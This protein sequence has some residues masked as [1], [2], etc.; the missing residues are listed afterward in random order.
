M[1]NHALIKNKQQEKS[2]IFT[3]EKLNEKHNWSGV[4]QTLYLQLAHLYELKGNK[5][6]AKKIRT[7]YIC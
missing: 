1:Y 4:D 2:E 6:K 3:R 7:A 5:K